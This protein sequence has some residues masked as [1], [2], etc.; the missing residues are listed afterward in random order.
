VRKTPYTA[1]GIKRLD[2]FRKCGR[3]ASSQWLICADGVYRPLC[4][5]CDIELNRLVLSFMCF[6]DAEKV[7]AEYI[8]SKRI[9]Q[10]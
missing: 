10:G 5:E 4:T 9:Q 3:K 8:E 7:M 1:A 2:C 6:L